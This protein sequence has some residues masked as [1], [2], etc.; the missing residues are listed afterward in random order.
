MTPPAPSARRASWLSWLLLLLG[1]CG[2][3]AVWVLLSLYT[4]RQHS[5]MAVLGALDI[6]WMLRLGGWRPGPRR[7]A[8]GVLATAAI[9]A[10]A[11]WWITASQLGATLGLDPWTSALRLGRHHA[12]MLIQLANGA[13]DLAWIVAGLIVAAWLSR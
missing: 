4:G 5:W 10:L 9:V 2:F 11:N 13:A 8:L 6:A 7:R 12:W 3:A 1:A